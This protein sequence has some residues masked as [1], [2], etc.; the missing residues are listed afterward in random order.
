MTLR[1]NEH[2]NYYYQGAAA[3]RKGLSKAI[4]PHPQMSIQ[5][6][7]WLAGWNDR[8]LGNIAK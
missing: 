4:C 5:G 8:D 6:A 1:F 2:N 7:W 3:H